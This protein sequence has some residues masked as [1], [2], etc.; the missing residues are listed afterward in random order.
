MSSTKTALEVHHR[1]AIA[2]MALVLTVT[3]MAALNLAH[4]DAAAEAHGAD[5]L[6]VLNP[7]LD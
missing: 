3:A 2:L 1:F 4:Q 7:E 6:L 5:Y